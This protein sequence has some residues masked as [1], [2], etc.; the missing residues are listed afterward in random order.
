MLLPCGLRMLA[1]FRDR[2]ARTAPRDLERG[3]K[4]SRMHSFPSTMALAWNW[5]WRAP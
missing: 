3:T 5:H 1:K 4:A 2:L